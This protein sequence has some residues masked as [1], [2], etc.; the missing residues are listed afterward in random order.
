MKTLNHAI[1]IG[2]SLGFFNIALAEAATL[3][4]LYAFSGYGGTGLTAGISPIGTLLRGAGGVLYGANLAGG[5]YFYGTLFRLSPPPPDSTQWTFSLLHTFTG[6]VDGGTPNASLVSDGGALYG[7]AQRGGPNWNQCGV[8]YKLTPPASE[9]GEWT[10]TVLHAFRYEY[11]GLGDGCNPG[12]GVIR[13]ASGAL[14][15][16]TI[17]GGKTYPSPCCGYGSVFKLSPPP[18]G[19][20][21][22]KET[23]L[24]RFAGGA[25]GQV[26]VSELT[27]DGAGA[28]YGTTLFG[29][30]G[31]CT[32]DYFNVV[33]CGTVFKLTPPAAGD[34]RW[35]KATLYRFAGGTNGAKPEGKL[36]L[37][38]AGAIYGTSYQGGRGK[39]TDLLSG[40]IIGCGTVYKLTP[41]APGE[42]GWK[43]TILHSFAGADGAFPGGGLITDAAGNLYGTAS[44]GGEA[45]YGVVFKLIR[46][47][48]GQTEW[49]EA[50]LH[51][52]NIST[53]GGLPIGELVA[54]PDGHF[55]GVTYSGGPGLG[56]TVFELIP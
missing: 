43:K 4:T 34:T 26:P 18:P 53:T 11:S 12:A 42:M 29:G 17:R 6:G 15:G 20:S 19:S 28:L 55:F 50:V 32:D 27:R 2:L 47:A 35:A 54:S 40:A 44:G 13:D 39:C 33:G 22:W 31:T 51:H 41:P 25:D 9:T 37:D 46:P 7:T 48:P 10:Q 23:V 14:Y 45:G 1:L 38:A 3:Q 5:A 56:G 21:T 49:R 24:Y 8:V 36:L 52:F 30:K 16:T